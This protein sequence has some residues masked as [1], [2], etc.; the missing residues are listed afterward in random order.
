MREIQTEATIEM[1]WDTETIQNDP[2]IRQTKI[3]QAIENRR[4]Y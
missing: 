2:T 3:Y 4:A 1:F